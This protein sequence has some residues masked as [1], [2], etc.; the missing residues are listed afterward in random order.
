MRLLIVRHGDP[1]YSIDSLTEKGE[2]EAKLL[3]KRLV[4]M[5]NRDGVHLYCSPLGRAQKTASHT[6]DA[7]GRTA[8]TLDW[9]REF[10]GSVKD[11]QGNDTCC[12]D[13]LPSD[14][15]EDDLCYTPL[16]YRWGQYQNTNVE[17]EY[18]RVCAG[19]DD[20]LARHGYRHSGRH[21]DV[22]QRSDDVVVLFCHFGVESVLLSHLFGVS[23][24]VFWHNTCALTTSVTTLVTEEREE[25]CAIFRMLSFGDLSHLWAGNEPSSFQARFCEQFTDGTRH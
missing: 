23:P 6:L 15:T 9:L 17:A 16:W 20:L 12:W 19:L 22:T 18:H 1:D 21:F 4:P 3:A 14:W 13:R 5:L 11:E 8:E 10:E 25:G 2:R 7:L 24:M